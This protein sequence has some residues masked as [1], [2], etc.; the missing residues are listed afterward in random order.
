ME[1]SPSFKSAS[2]PAVTRIYKGEIPKPDMPGVKLEE[3]VYVEMRDGVRIAVDLY[4][5]EKEG[6]YPVLLSMCP[7]LKEMQQCHPGWCH[8]IEAGA[9][10]FLVPKGYIHVIAQ[11]RG[12]GMS[13]GRWAF[14]DRKEQQD[15]YDLIEWIADQPWCD[16]NVGMIGDSYWA[17]IQFLVA[18]QRPPHL[19]CIVPHDG[20]TDMYRDAMY[21]GG[22]FNG[23]EFANHWTVDTIFQCIWPGPVEGKEPPIHFAAE[24]ASHPC[25][26]PFYR[27]RSAWWMAD[28]IEVPALVCV[29]LTPLH[30]RGQLSI[31]PRI[32]SPKKLL[33]E[34]ETGYWAHLRFVT[35]QHL[36][37]VVLR[38][39]D[40]WLKGKDT[41]IMREPEVAIF[42]G[43]T[44]KWRYENEYP[45]ER[46]EWTKYYLHGGKATGKNDP[47]QG[48]LT[49]QPP[50][51]ERP[52]K[53]KLPESTRLL[54]EGKPVL[55]YSTPPLKKAVPVWGPLG[56]VLYGSSTEKDTVWFVK[57]FDQGPGKEMKLLSRGILRA[58]FRAVDQERSRPGQP[59]HLFEEQVPLEPKKTYEFQIEM[60]PIFHTFQARH[61]I[62]VEIA[63]DD[64][65][66][67]GS[68]HSLD[69]QGLPMPVENTIHHDSRFP[70]HLLLP[71]IPDA[72]ILKKVEP[73]LSKVEWP[74][75]PGNRW[76]STSGGRLRAKR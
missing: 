53:Y 49:L 21:Q 47:L 68:L 61:R 58:S 76:P 31:Y 8:S 57:L 34:P 72:P 7:Y 39:L 44:R 16:G 32:R 46:T 38:W 27:E 74:L 70:S 71:V 75:V 48:T 65:T 29:T 6:R 5:P 59:F 69:I 17:W 42:D 22:V 60:K 56:A 33:V 14:L 28:R 23:G 73:P 10:G 41:G 19:K 45:V 1:N 25:D 24:L 18:A 62:R 40:H 11:S 54:L 66:Y 9:T 26:G 3:N 67:F 63:S 20:G 4:H 15:G 36:N 13:Q 51:A 64:L 50:A 30:S 52:D 12:S 37:E 35:D 55:V 43:A 2:K